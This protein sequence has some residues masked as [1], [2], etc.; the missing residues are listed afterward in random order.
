MSQ[1]IR[2][3]EHL[4]KRLETHAKGF[5][6]PAG[7][8]ERVLSFYEK[9]RG[10][11]IGYDN[12][13][14][15]STPDVTRRETSSAIFKRKN[16]SA[17]ATERF[18]REIENGIY[19]ITSPGGISK[20]F[21]LPNVNDKQAIQELTHRVEDFVKDQGGKIG[22]ITSARKKLTEFGYHITKQ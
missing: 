9:H 3:P 21:N 15:S 18:R 4:Y 7:V 2:I 13:L 1:V 14:E 12:S 6:T 19:T 20:S 22:Q 5:D 10:Q 11:E 16:S 17:C 8:I